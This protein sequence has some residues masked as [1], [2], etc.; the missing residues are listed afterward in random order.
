MARCL[1]VAPGE[2]LAE[3]DLGVLR[4]RLRAHPVVTEARVTRVASTLVVRIAERQPA[5]ALCDLDGAES[6]GVLV[7]DTGCRLRPGSPRCLSRVAAHLRQRRDSATSRSRCPRR[8][9]RPPRRR[10]LSVAEWR[11]RPALGQFRRSPLARFHPKAHPRARGSQRTVGSLGPCL[12]VP[13]ERRSG[14]HRPTLSQPGSCWD[15]R[16]PTW[17]RPQPNGTRASRRNRAGHPGGDIAMARRGER[18]V[19]PRYRDHQ[20]LLRRRRADGERR[21][22]GGGSGPIRRGGL[23]KGGGRRYPG[24][25]GFDRARHR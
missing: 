20:D 3:L 5:A 19:G 22:R 13:R 6:G 25:R 2:P 24:H 7:D 23:R 4:D 11:L 17:M 16:P 12:D 15:P 18:I 10:A 21:G 8:D 9:A 14:H 1:A